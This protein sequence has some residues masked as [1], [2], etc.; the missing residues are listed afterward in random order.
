MKIL[1]YSPGNLETIARE[2]GKPL[3]EIKAA[4]DTSVVLRLPIY[5]VIDFVY[6]GSLFRSADVT[7]VAAEIINEHYR[8]TESERAG[9]YTSV[10]VKYRR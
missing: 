10:E 4:Y 7:Y 2:T 3:D 8:R 1:K 6:F 5:S 9:H